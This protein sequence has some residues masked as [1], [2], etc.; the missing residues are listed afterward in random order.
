M[1]KK[2]TMS[3]ADANYVPFDT[4]FTARIEEFLA[5]GDEENADAWLAAMKAKTEAEQAIGATTSVIDDNTVTMSH[6]VVVEAFD[7]VFNQWVNQFDVQF[8]FEEIES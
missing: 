1:Q 5:R 8:T 4:W 6:E 7:N 2:I 3:S